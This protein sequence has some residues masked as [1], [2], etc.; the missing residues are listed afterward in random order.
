MTIRVVRHILYDG[1]V[2][3]LHISFPIVVISMILLEAYRDF[4]ALDGCMIYTGVGG[5][6]LPTLK[7]MLSVVFLSCFFDEEDS[8]VREPSLLNVRTNF[9]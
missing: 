6:H 9:E 3:E 8:D 1:G 2:Y 5:N 4:G 7:L